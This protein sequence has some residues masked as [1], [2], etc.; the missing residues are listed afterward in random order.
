HA[1]E[2]LEEL[3]ED[4]TPARKGRELIHNSDVLP[5]E[6]VAI[7]E[8]KTWQRRVVMSLEGKRDMV[9]VALKYWEIN[10]QVIPCGLAHLGTVGDFETYHKISNYFDEDNK[11]IVIPEGSYEIRDINKYCI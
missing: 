3:L 6:Y 2:D 1:R 8:R 11:E 5:D 9:I 4:L 7:C 10:W